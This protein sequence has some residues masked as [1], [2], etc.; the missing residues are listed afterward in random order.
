[1]NRSNGNQPIK[2]TQERKSNTEGWP[3]LAPMNSL[4]QIQGIKTERSSNSSQS[5]MTAP[6]LP[7]ST[8]A[9]PTTH[10]KSKGKGGQPPP[11]METLQWRHQHQLLETRDKGERTRA[12]F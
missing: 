12:A 9:Q 10:R 8:I 3:P 2:A 1:M 5:N 4:N 7:Q 11:E 6:P